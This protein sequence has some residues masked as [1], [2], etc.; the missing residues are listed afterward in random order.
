MKTMILAGF[1]EC[2]IHY[3]LAKLKNKINENPKQKFCKRKGVVIRF[4]NILWV[5][6]QIALPYLSILML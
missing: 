2:D 6:I 1:L 4:L 5:L 3:S